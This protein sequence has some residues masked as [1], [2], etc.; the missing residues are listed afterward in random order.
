[1]APTSSLL[2][3]NGTVLVHDREDHVNP[4]KADILIVDNK[5][6]E[7]APSI[8]PASDA[9][10]I[11][12]TGKILSPG[13]IDTHHHMWQTQLKGRHADDLLLDYLFKGYVM[14]SLFKADDVFWGELGGCLEALDGGV[15]TVVDHAHINNSAE[16]SSSALSATVASGIRS[17]F[18]YSPVPQR[19]VASWAPFRF[20]E[21]G[22]PLPDWSTIQLADLAANQ[23]FG[24][25]RVRLGIA[26]D[27]YYLPKNMVMSLFERARETRCQTFYVSLC[28]ESSFGPAF[29]C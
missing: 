28:S 11:D 23:P 12:C 3:S 16:H 8:S 21:A 1:M 4:I 10:N 2:L 25:G 27:A 17:Y 15:T 29:R 24:N 5:I 22:N 14:A 7:I 6:V 13:F 9:V 18:C 19:G 26:F 20:E